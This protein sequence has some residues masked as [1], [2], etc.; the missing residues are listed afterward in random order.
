MRRK[1]KERT[2]QQQVV[3]PNFFVG[4]KTLCTLA[5]LIKHRDGSVR[6]LEP[7][8]KGRGALGAPSEAE[9]P[10]LFSFFSQRKRLFEANDP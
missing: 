9:F 7:P 5:P 6:K 1:G 4:N 2:K 8:G 3:F 10:N